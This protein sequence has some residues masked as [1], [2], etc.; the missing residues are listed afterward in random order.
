MRDRSV[1]VRLAVLEQTSVDM[2][3]IVKDHESRIRWIE[4]VAMYGMGT[5]GIGSFLLS[6]FKTVKP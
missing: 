4:R 2:G 3:A 5:L 6:V 1:E